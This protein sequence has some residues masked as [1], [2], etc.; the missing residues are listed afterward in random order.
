MEFLLIIPIFLIIL[1]P[2]I[3]V[4]E[5]FIEFA[6]RRPPS[7]KSKFIQHYVFAGIGIGLPLL[8]FIYNSSLVDM[9]PCGTPAMLQND[10]ILGFMIWYCFAFSCFSISYFTKDKRPPLIELTLPFGLLL[11]ALVSLILAYHI[12]FDNFLTYLGAIPVAII[13][14]RQLWRNQKRVH[15]HLVQLQGEGFWTKLYLKVEANY[16]LKIPMIMALAFPIVAI[17]TAVLYLFGQKP[18]DLIDAFRETCSYGLSDAAYCG[19]CVDG[20]YLCTIAAYGSPKLVKPLRAGYRHG[21]KIIVNR[22]LLASNAFEELLEE[23]SPRLHSFLRK[24]YDL[25]GLN[26][27]KQLHKA[28]CSNFTYLLMKPLEWAFIFC[29]Y[30]GT[31]NPENR[32]NRQYRK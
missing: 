22:Q 9:D 13:Y 17:M 14:F 11:G 27:A 4:I 32:I 3:L 7:F 10:R 20:H 25:Y 29:L 24:N 31:I 5:L 19:E 1:S 23:K 6:E 12:G 30:L 15:K 2:V 26:L 8:F 18:D 28:R 16:W 21:K